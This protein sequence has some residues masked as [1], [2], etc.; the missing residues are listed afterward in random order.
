MTIIGP[1]PCK[2]CKA[3]VVYDGKVWREVRDLWRGR[4]NECKR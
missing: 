1:V 3:M 4:P 2:H